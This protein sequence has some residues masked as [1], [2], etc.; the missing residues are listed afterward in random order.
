MPTDAMY[1]SSE[2]MSTSSAIMEQTSRYFTVSGRERL[3]LCD[4]LKVPET[5][6]KSLP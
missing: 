5:A 1:F 4:F 6:K 3:I 2:K